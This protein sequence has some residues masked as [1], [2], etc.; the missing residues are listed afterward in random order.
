[1]FPHNNL[2]PC[3]VTLIQHHVTNRTLKMAITTRTRL[4]NNWFLYLTSCKL[5]N[6]SPFSVAKHF[7]TNKAVNCNVVEVSKSNQIYYLSLTIFFHHQFMVIIQATW[8]TQPRPS[9]RGRLAVTNDLL[10]WHL[11]VD[12]SLFSWY[13]LFGVQIKLPRTRKRFVSASSI[14][15]L[16]R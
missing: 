7:S 6:F 10:F 5:P 15:I 16:S 14:Y 4:R 1:M 12:I 8:K 2:A 13:L 11:L 9:G 3:H